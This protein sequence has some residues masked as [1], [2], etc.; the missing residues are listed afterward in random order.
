MVIEIVEPDKHYTMLCLRELCDRYPG[1]DKLIIK[2]RD[3]YI[4]TEVM[5]D[6]DRLMAMALEVLG[7][8]EV[9]EVDL[10]QTV[11]RDGKAV[12]L[13][14]WLNMPEPK[15][16]PPTQKVAGKPS[17]ADMRRAKRGN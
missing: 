15:H 7:G 14:Q 9:E 6:E 16:K 2:I 1:K 12:P 11:V 5:V 8:R 3:H 10:T 4:E 17:I 13:W